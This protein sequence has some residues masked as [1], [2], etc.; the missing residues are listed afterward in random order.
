MFVDDFFP[1]GPRAIGGLCP[2]L[3]LASVYVRNWMERQPE[4]KE[5]SVTDWFLDW[6]QFHCPQLAYA[7][8][9]RHEEG[10]VTGADWE[11]WIVARGTALKIRVQAKR[12]KEAEDNYPGITHS[13][14]HGMQIDKLIDDAEAQDALA[15]YAFYA[16]GGGACN[17]HACANNLDPF[18]VF[19]AD[20]HRIRDTFVNAARQ[21]V[22]KASVL[23]HCASLHCLFCCARAPGGLG[24]GLA[25]VVEFAGLR[26]ASRSAYTQRFRNVRGFHAEVPPSIRVLTEMRE[27]D[28]RQRWFSDYGLE[29]QDVEALI[30]ID[31]DAPA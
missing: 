31:L 13:N 27:P 30:V 11:W 20:A 29:F 8:F 16:V 3:Q 23:Q 25:A 10:R 24:E 18:A 17:S 15:L 2:I 5:E 9:T 6:T 14:A 28:L 26:D 22:P 4:V 7:S 21:P 1:N 19:V 12:L